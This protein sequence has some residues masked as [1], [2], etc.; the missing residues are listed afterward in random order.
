MMENNNLDMNDARFYQE[1]MPL[2]FNLLKNIF[3]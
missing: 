3:E 2:P 1:T